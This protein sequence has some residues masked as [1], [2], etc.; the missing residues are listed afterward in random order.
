MHIAS[1]HSLLQVYTKFLH[2]GVV[3]RERVGGGEEHDFVVVAQVEL[4]EAVDHEF[5]AAA[6]ALLN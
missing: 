1:L 5:G 3:V 2:D 6:I 4:Q